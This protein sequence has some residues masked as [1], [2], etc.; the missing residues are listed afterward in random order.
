M[1]IMAMVFRGAIVVSLTTLVLGD[2]HVPPTSSAELAAQAREEARNIRFAKNTLIALAAIA[3]AVALY[4]L[5]IYS[6][7]HIRTLVSI[8]NTTQRYFKPPSPLFA[9]IKQ[10]ILYAPL[11]RMRHREEYRLLN[12]NLGILP[13]RFQCL[14]FIG[15]IAMNIAH[16]IHGIPWDGPQAEM[17]TLLGNRAGTLSIANMIPLVIMAGRNNPLIVILNISFDTFNAIHRLFG[18]MVV[19]QALVHSVALIS[20]TVH[21]GSIGYP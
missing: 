1:A 21:Q 4:R 15:V 13:S 20:R 11:F 16:C 6:V 8:N 10:H 9:S 19:I 18:R 17:L 14:F 5:A 2:G 12:M 3:I 7:R